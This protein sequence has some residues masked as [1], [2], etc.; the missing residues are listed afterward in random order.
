MK[1]NRYKLDYCIPLKSGN[2]IFDLNPYELHNGGTYG[3]LY[4]WKNNG[5][6]SWRPR[7]GASNYNKDKKPSECEGSSWVNDATF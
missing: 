5:V 4:C 3:D 1:G 7:E 6:E 2:L